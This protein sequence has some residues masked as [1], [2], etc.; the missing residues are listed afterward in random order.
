MTQK[1]AKELCL[2]LWRYLAEHPEC[3]YKRQVPRGIYDK[4]RNLKS[5][6]P[7]C[8]VF[9]IPPTYCVACPLYNANECCLD[10]GSLWYRWYHTLFYELSERKESA[11]RIV[12]IVSAWEP[13]EE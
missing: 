5:K 6:C 8:E 12:E 11:M 9:S 2:E 3:Y 10:D 4:V 7:L 13:K 1:E